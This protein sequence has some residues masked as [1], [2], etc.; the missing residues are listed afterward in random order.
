MSSGIR[1]DLSAALEADETGDS[2]LLMNGDCTNHRDVRE[3]LIDVKVVFHL[4][5]NPEV[6]L[7]RSGSETCFQHNLFTTH[8]IFG[9]DEA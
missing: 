8:V 2:L 9:R 4:A 5:G 6:R 7:D 3:A 1:A